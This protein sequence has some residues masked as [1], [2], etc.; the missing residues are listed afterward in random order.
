METEPEKARAMATAAHQ[1]NNR[2]RVSNKRPRTVLDKWMR[3][4]NENAIK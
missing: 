1:R 4:Q 2:L 3:E